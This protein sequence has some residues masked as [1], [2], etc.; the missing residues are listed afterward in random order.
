MHG[1]DVTGNEHTVTL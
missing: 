1:K